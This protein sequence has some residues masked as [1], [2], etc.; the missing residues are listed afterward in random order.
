MLKRDVVIVDPWGNGNASYLHGLVRSLS[1]KVNIHLMTSGKYENKENV[2]VKRIFFLFSDRM[3]D[4]K[5]RHIVRGIEYIIAYMYIIA[6]VHI[7]KCSV[8]HIQWLLLYGLDCYILKI[9]SSK[10]SIIYTAHNAIPHIDNKNNKAL[11]Q[12]YNIVDKIIVHGNN[13]KRELRNIFNIDEAKIEII[14]HGIYENATCEYMETREVSKLKKYISMYDRVWLLEGNIFYNKGFDRIIKI[15]L[16]KFRKKNE[17][18]VVAGKINER[19]AELTQLLPYMVMQNDILFIPKFIEENT[20][21][22]L[23]EACDVFL[24][25]YRHASMSG[26]IFSSALH[27]KT[28]IA[29][30]VGAIPEYIDNVEG[31]FLCEN[32]DNEILKKMLYVKQLPKEDL[33]RL[34]NEFYKYVYKNYNWDKIA[35]QTISLY[36]N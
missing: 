35:D 4:G 13:I 36:D 21:T 8:I 18:L 24:L 27:K 3:S 23:M 33:S 7:K 9:L 6:Y 19:Y 26:V 12:I 5:L 17:L 2:K 10:C 28:L 32:V 29:T 30:K 20:M 1:K 16:E 25:P 22:F 34:G 11:K 15:W 14:P 31:A